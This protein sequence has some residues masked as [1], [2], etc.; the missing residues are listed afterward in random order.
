MSIADKLKTIA[1]NETKVFKAGQMSVLS[2]SKALK[3]SAQGKSIVIK[4]ISSI[5][6]DVDVSIMPQPPMAGL[7][8]GCTFEDTD[9]GYVRSTPFTVTADGNY[10][11]A[12]NL[13]DD[14]KWHDWVVAWPT[15]AADDS[16]WYNGIHNPSKGEWLNLSKGNQHRLFLGAYKGLKAADIL[17][18]TI[19]IG[20]NVVAPS[21][22]GGDVNGVKVRIGDGSSYTEH[23]SNADGK[24]EGIKSIYPT[25]VIST[26]AE[27]MIISTNYIKDIDKAL[28]V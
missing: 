18:A 10:T 9:F 21:V 22:G 11:I 2:S 17:S 8:T 3:G 7:L 5:E 20:E 28:G 15:W 6:H 4:D 23:T 26:D 25:M 13:S 19:E 24:I 14:S 12:L 16:P 27:G 1:E